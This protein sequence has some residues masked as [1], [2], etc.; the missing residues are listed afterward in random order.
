M[1]RLVFDGG[2]FDGVGA[3]S[4]DHLQGMHE[5]DQRRHRQTDLDRAKVAVQSGR[6]QNPGEE[7]IVDQG[8]QTGQNRRQTQKATEMFAR[9]NLIS[10]SLAERA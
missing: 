5:G 7:R 9:K 8:Y 3:T 2:V 1:L 4:P 10:N 6:G